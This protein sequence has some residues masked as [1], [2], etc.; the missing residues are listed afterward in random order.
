MDINVYFIV[1]TDRWDVDYSPT[2]EGFLAEAEAEARAKE[3]T[4]ELKNKQDYFYVVGECAVKAKEKICC[5]CKYYEEI[6]DTYGVCRHEKM[7]HDP[8][9]MEEEEGAWTGEGNLLIDVG[10]R[11]G[12]NLWEEKK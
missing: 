8:V 10:R 12:C 6:I 9:N 7:G 3:L 2:G 4:D 5:G 11:Y 1:Y